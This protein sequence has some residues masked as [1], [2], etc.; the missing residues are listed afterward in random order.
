[1]VGFNDEALEYMLNKMKADDSFG[2]EALAKDVFNYAMT[3][4]LDYMT[5][6]GIIKDG[7]FTDAYYDEDDA[8]DFIIDRTSNAMSDVEGDVIAELIELYFE[9]HD[10]FMEE[11][12]LLDWE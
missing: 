10:A 2:N 5:K 11:K 1:M 7:E 4:D 8:F 9:Y 6:A 3:Y 12:G